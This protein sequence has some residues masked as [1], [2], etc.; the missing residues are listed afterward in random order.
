MRHYED[1]LKIKK[2]HIPTKINNMS[3]VDIIGDIHGYADKLEELLMKLGYK[4]YKK[5]F[6]HDNRKVIFVGDYIDRGPDNVRVIEL[7]KNMVESGN[8][9]ALCGNHEHNAICFNTKIENGYLRLRT[10]KNINQHS[11]TLRQFKG[12]QTEYDEMIQWFKTLPL[13][14]ETEQYRVVHATWDENAINYLKKNTDK[15]ILKDEQY[16]ELINK[17]SLLFKAIEITCKGKEERLPEGKSFLDK[18][19]NERKDIRVKWWLNPM[20]TSL[21]EISIV[22]NLGLSEEILEGGEVSYYNE[23][24]VPVFFGH[25]WLKGEP[26]LYRNN[27]CCL[28]YSIAKNGY[29]CSYRYNGE[30]ELDV[31][32]LVY[33]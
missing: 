5:G 10:E 3:N 26:N 29:L 20:K 30:T 14:Y 9:I 15:G 33:V 31:E 12:K 32:N 6:K 21:K 28:D 4:R 25:Y 19:G 17:E 11:E 16:L 7:V 13:Y 18:D 1:S 22:E 2:M 8:A 27:I 24:Q 23:L